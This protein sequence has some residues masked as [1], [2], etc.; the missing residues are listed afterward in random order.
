MGTTNQKTT[1]KQSKHN[2]KDSQQITR[3]EIKRRRE[4]KRPK[5]TVQNNKIA[6]STYLSIITLTVNGI[7]LQLKDTDW[8]NGY[9]NK[10][11]IY[12]IYKRPTSAL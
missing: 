5:I 1:K 6:T 3:E 8:M 11:Q 10:I 12:A 9:K 4:G 2:T 7:I